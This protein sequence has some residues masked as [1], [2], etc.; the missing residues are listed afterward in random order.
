MKYFNKKFAKFN[1]MA[2]KDLIIVCNVGF[3]IKNKY[4]YPAPAEVGAAP[5]ELRP[6]GARV[7]YMSQQTD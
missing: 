2:N 7:I 3:K 5:P 4:D 6:R 1:I